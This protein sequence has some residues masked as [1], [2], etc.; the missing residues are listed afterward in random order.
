MRKKGYRTPE[1]V[2]VDVELQLMQTFSGGDGE[3]Q[4]DP[5]EDLSEDDNRSRRS[6]WDFD[7]DDDF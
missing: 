2:V 1:T 3:T 5:V 7:D 4:V 6:Y